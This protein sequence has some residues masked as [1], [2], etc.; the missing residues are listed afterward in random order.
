MFR[1]CQD[2]AYEHDDKSTAAPSDDCS[3]PRNDVDPLLNETSLRTQKTREF[4]YST[5][6]IFINNNSKKLGVFNLLN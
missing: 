6:E 1:L 3:V 4:E 5:I 2:T